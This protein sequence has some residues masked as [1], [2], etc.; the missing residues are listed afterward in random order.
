MTSQKTMIIEI[1]LKGDTTS[2]RAKHMTPILSWAP[3]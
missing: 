2:L 1:E 3:G